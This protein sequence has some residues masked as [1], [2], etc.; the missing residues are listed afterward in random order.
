MNDGASDKPSP[1][2]DRTG[3]AAAAD[4]QIDLAR[5]LA[6]RAH[7]GQTDRHGNPFITHPGRVAARTPAW[8]RPA[9]WLHDVLEDTPV[10]AADL[11]AAGVAPDTVAAVVLVS[12]LDTGHGLP[13][14]AG[15]IDRIATAA[16]EP[17]RIARIV[18]L[19]DNADNL[20]RARLKDADRAALL[21][22]RYLA[23]R[24]VLSAAVAARG[25][26]PLPNP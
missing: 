6:R 19:A 7:A 13:D 16:G 12:R 5:R 4:G 17:G 9:A 25:E 10:T 15:Y 20:S 23:A 11:L 14:Y 26:R 18:K 1:E 2:S 3:L 21:R 22:R 8:A 24:K